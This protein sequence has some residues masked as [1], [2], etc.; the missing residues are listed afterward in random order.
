VEQR[1]L[2]AVRCREH[3]G[4]IIPGTKAYEPKYIDAPGTLIEVGGASPLKNQ[5]PIIVSEMS[6]WLQPRAADPRRARGQTFARLRI[7]LMEP[8][9]GC[10]SRA[11]IRPLDGAGASRI[12]AARRREQHET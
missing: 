1:K 2:L 10:R 4:L 11:G 9:F 6:S 7:S 3:L 12:Q 8:G 5:P